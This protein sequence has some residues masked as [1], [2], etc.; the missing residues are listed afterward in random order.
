MKRI[1][2]TLISLALLAACAPA[3]IATPTQP[4]TAT[5]S[6]TLTTQLSFVVTQDKPN[7][8]TTQPTTNK[9]DYKELGIPSAFKKLYD[10]A[11]AKNE[12]WLTKAEEVVSQAAG[13]GADKI[14]IYNPAPDKAAAIVFSGNLE[15]D[16]VKQIEKWIE[17][18]KRGSAWEVDWIGA[19]FMCRRGSNTTQWQK[20]F[21]P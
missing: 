5:P 3:P 15:D 7:N 16:S 4:P 17:M 12:S 20:E 21:C 13:K 6:P 11:K 14:S 19:R 10:E 18:M 8:P 9:S 1:L 2:F